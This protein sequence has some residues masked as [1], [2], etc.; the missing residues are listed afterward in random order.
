MKAL[1]VNHSDSF[2]SAFPKPLVC[3]LLEIFF[4]KVA[5]FNLTLL[6]KPEE[7]TVANMRLKRN[8]ELVGWLSVSV[9]SLSFIYC[10]LIVTYFG[11]IV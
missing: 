3:Q 2:S 10:D 11:T 6:R 8:A 7:S 1:K 9:F 4:K 5:H